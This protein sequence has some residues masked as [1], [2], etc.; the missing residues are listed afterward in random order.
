MRDHA[1]QIPVLI[2]PIAGQRYRARTGEPLALCVE[3]STVEEVERE[4]ARIVEE[5]IRQGARIVTVNVSNGPLS[6]ELPFPADDLYQSDR[7]F[8]ELQEAIV[9]NRR[10]EDE[11]E[12]NSAGAKN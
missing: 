12:S 6:S 9:E 11:A 1:M 8:R 2:E 3:G 5:R 10:I 4:V 7:G